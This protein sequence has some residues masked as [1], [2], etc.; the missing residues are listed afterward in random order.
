ML[1]WLWCTLQ[2]CSRPVQSSKQGQPLY[3]KE[4]RC[5][6]PDQ[7]L[8]SKELQCSKLEQQCSRSLS[9]V[10]RG[11]SC[12]GVVRSLGVV[13]RWSSGVIRSLGVSWRSIVAWSSLGFGINF[14]GILDR[15]RSSE[16]E[17]HSSLERRRLWC[18]P[19]WC[20]NWARCNRQEQLWCS[21]L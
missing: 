4:P 17:E 6:K 11:G 8:C 3:N 2:L 5:S 21:K 13:D 16:P 7:Q 12:G 9:V 1:L 15:S 14:R 19:R 20:S 10:Y 18:K